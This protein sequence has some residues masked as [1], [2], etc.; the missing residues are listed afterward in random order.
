MIDLSSN[1]GGNSDAA[2]AV[3]CWF[4]GE[5]RFS[6]LDT[7]TG[8]ETIACYRTDL[9]LNGVALSDPAGGSGTY[10]PGDTVSGQYN[11]YCLISPSSFSCGNLVPAIFDQTGGITLIGQ[12]SGGGSNVVFPATTA[13]GMIFQMSGPLQITTYSNGSLY[14]VDVGVEPHVRLSKPESFYDREALVEMI[15]NLK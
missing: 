13:S 5:A 8:A 11:L 1:G 15:H 14:G 2:I 10:D 9:N 3:A 12:R 7:M 6:L 4:T